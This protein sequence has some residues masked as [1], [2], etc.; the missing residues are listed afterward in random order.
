MIVLF[1]LISFTCFVFMIIGIFSP[2]TSLFWIK[3]ENKRKKGTS[4]VFYFLSSIFFSFLSGLA[5]DNSD[6]AEIVKQDNSVQE[7]PIT[8]EE[9]PSNWEY[10]TDFD[11]MNERTMYFATC[12]SLNYHEFEFPYNGGSFLSLI[13]R[14]MNGKNEVLVKI[15][16]GQIHG[17]LNNEVIRFKFDD[18]KPESYYFSSAADGSSDVA[19]ITQS[20][21][22]INKIRKAKK[23]KVDIP[24]FQEGRPVFDFNI[25]GLK[26]EY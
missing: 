4:F 7:S 14:N 21:R 24:I 10:S 25:E 5:V 3:D 16:K 2:K 19:F 13:V 26:W 9:A 15:S 23:V 20:S 1:G 11:E 8:A 18:G 12:T 17:S 6:S 22:L